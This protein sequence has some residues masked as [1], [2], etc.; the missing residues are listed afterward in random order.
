MRGLDRPGRVGSGYVFLPA[1]PG[2]RW[3]LTIRSRA[4]KADVTMSLREAAEEFLA[5]PRVAVAGLSRDAKQPANLIYRRLRDTGH[6]VF[7]VNPNAS[8]VESDRCVP[9][10]TAIPGGVDGVVVA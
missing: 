7:A 1:L 4:R 3:R 6:T 5:Q 10:V 2:G 9:T 8:E